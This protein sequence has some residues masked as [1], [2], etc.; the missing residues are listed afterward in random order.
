MLLQGVAW[1]EDVKM[2]EYILMG[3]VGLVLVLTIVQSFQINSLSENT[4]K[5]AITGNAVKTTTGIIDTSGW[6]E[7][8]KMEY[9]HH[10]TLPERLQGS[11]QSSPS[12]NMVGG[13]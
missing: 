9:E 5:N 12:N 1:L 6:T 3:L 10:G 2:K 11:G 7:T 8:E 4:N 13:C